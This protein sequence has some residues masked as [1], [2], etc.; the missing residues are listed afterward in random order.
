VCPAG[1]TEEI[2]GQAGITTSHK[3][4]TAATFNPVSRSTPLTPMAIAAPKLFSPSAR[5]TTSCGTTMKEHLANGS[6]FL[7]QAQQSFDHMNNPG[8]ANSMA[9]PGSCTGLGQ[10]TACRT[11]APTIMRAPAVALASHMWRRSAGIE[12]AIPTPIAS[13]TPAWMALD[14]NCSKAER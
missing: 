13:P 3:P 14:A 10:P 1:S 9:R 2:T 11:P 7:P 5:A 6:W 8:L 12:Y 4:K